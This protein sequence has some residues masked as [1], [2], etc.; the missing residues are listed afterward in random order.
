MYSVLQQKQQVRA[1]FTVTVL[2]EG[3]KKKKKKVFFEE[4]LHCFFFTEEQVKLFQT[5]NRSG[6]TQKFGIRENTGP[7]AVNWKREIPY[8]QYQRCNTN[9]YGK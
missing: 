2:I 6:S 7:E 5:L 4:S 9:L 1:I 3:S 8:V